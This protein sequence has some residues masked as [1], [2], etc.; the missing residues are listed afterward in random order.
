MTESTELTTSSDSYLL[1][2]YPPSKA[3]FVRGK[4]AF[5]FDDAGKEYLDFLGG[6]ATVSLGHANDEIT[7][8]AS[9]QLATLTHVSNFFQN[10]YTQKVARTIDEK[11]SEGTGEPHGRVFFSNS[12]AE[13]NE[14]AI[15]IAKRYG[16]GKKHKILTA[17]GSF[18]GRTLATLAAT[19]QVEKHKNFEPLPPFFKH[20]EYNNIDSLVSQIDDECIA[21]M[22]EVIQGENGVRVGSEEFLNS[23]NSV[24]TEHGLLLIIDE[25]QTGMC[26]TGSWFGFQNYGIKPDIV[27]M[28]KALGNGFPVGAC[29]AAPDIAEVMSPGDHGSTFG[30][31]PLALSVV[32]SVFSIMERDGIAQRTQ[33]LGEILKQKLVDTGLFSEVRGAGLLVGCDLDPSLGLSAHELV[34][35]S[36]EAGL[37]IN[38]TSENTIRLAPPLIIEESH[39]DQAVDIINRVAKE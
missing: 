5:L 4:G 35:R 11:I 24:C 1:N 10:E 30:G 21:V 20:F 38:A 7:Q 32:D 17:F 22:I 6:I 9:Q 15:K 3:T 37:V 2:T 14:C 19:G 8:A 12:G 27:T 29:W 18:H 28:A 16:G 34:T 36:L 23:L 31:Q 26:R 25:V 39:I 33:K 13:A